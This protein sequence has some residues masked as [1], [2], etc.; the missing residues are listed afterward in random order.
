VSATEDGWI[1]GLGAMGIGIAAL[2]LGAGR[3]TK[4]DSIDHAVGIICRTKRGDRVA[5][6]DV[7]AEVHARDEADAEQAAE[8]VSA[9]YRIGPEEPAARS[10]VLG[11]VR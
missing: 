9:A 10:I 1:T 3:R 5:R 7:L 2:H 11:I 8:A 6:G 4:E